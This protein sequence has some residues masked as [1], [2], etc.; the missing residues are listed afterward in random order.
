M[1]REPHNLLRRQDIHRKDENRAREGQAV[2]V[3]DGA[4]GRLPAEGLT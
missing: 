4:M 1:H 2:E 3:R